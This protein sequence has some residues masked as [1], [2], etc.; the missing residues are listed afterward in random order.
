V[1]LLVETRNSLD[2]FLDLSI[3]LINVHPLLGHAEDVL[4]R[5]RPLAE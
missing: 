3:N 2:I 5:L 4:D 1:A